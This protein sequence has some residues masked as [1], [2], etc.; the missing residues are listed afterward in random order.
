MVEDVD[1]IDDNGNKRDFIAYVT[2]NYEGNPEESTANTTFDSAQTEYVA[3]NKYVPTPIISHIAECDAC[4]RASAA[5]ICPTAHG[6]VCHDRSILAICAAQLAVCCMRANVW[7]SELA[8][9]VYSEALPPEHGLSD[10]V[11]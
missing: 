1:A 11:A 6:T 2:V 10:G 4:R 3:A 7:R 8:V 5:E 9:D